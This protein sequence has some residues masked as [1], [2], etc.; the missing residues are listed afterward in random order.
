M[1]RPSLVL[2][3]VF[4]GWGTIPLLV[5]HVPVPAA[6]IV[7]SRLAVAAVALGLVLLVQRLRRPL[8]AAP[9]VPLFR[10][11]PVLCV[12]TQVT[13]ACHWLALFAAY[14][15]AASGTVI[16]IVYLAPVGVAALAPRTLGESV[17]RATLVALAVAGAGFLL[18]AAPAVESSSAAGLLLAV[19]AAALFVVLVLVSKPLAEAYGGLR[20]AFMEMAGAAVV[21]AP[22]ALL[23]RWGSPRATWALLLVLGLVHTAVGIA[24]YLGVLARIPATHVAILGYLEPA[25]VVV[26]GW[27]FLSESPSVETVLGGALI[28]VAGVL[29]IRAGRPVPTPVEVPAG[30]PR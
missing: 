17:N 15:R 23:A 3:A 26:F 14:K 7:F 25:A 10:I 28:V 21:L 9:P 1:R 2:V 4:V 29:V 12:V 8:G 5:R 18:V 22:F 27:L 6:A 13:L 20:L 16:L 19:I 30:V 24:V 11:R